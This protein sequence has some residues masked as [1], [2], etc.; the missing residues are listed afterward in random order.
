LVI[1][2]D[3]LSVKPYYTTLWLRLNKISVRREDWKDQAA[4]GNAFAILAGVLIS[5]GP[6]VCDER[7]RGIDL[8]GEGH[9]NLTL[10]APHQARGQSSQESSII[11]RTTGV[12][13]VWLFMM[14][15]E[16]R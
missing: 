3:T 9:L 4:P 13:A 5:Y 12:F 11:A 15:G 7:S 16:E 2:G 10:L 1:H 14:E 8:I 6:K